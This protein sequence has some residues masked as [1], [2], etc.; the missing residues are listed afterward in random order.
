MKPKRKTEFEQWY[1]DKKN[2]PSYVFDFQK[3]L[4][5][6]CQSDVKLLQKGREVFSKNFQDVAAFNP[7]EKC[8]TI[9]SA[10]NLCYKK[11]RL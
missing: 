1:Q 11:D 10:C 8:M 3:E 7:F 9:A 5:A 2:H 4:L 6:Y